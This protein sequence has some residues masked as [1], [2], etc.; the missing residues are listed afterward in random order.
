M[1]TATSA[2]YTEQR[3]AR[4]KL[5]VFAFDPGLG[6][7]LETLPISELTLA[8]GWE[9]KLGMGPV[10]EYVEVVDY[11][12][13]SAVFYAP[14][15]LN[16]SYLLA[17]EGLAP[18]EGIPQFHQQMVYAVAMNTI[19]HFERALGRV[20]LWAPR[21]I[22]DKQGRFLSAE[23][24]PRLRIY[25][26]ALREANAYYCPSKRAI[27]FGYCPTRGGGPGQLPGG[28][29]FTCLSYDIVAH[30]TTHALL[31]GLHPRFNEATNPDVYAL[32]EA[33]ADLVALLQRFAHPE[34]LEHQIAQTGG[35]LDRQNMLGQVAQQLG[36]ALGMRGALRSFLGTTERQT[37]AWTPLTPKPELLARTTE[38]HARGGILVAAV[39]SAFLAIYKARSA[40]LFRIASNGTGVMPEGNLHPDLVHR[41]AREAADAADDALTM[42]IRGLDYCPPVDV[43]FGV[44]LRAIITADAELYPEDRY[45]YRV[46]FI[47]AF[48][49]WGIYPEGIHSMSESVLR[50][51]RMAR[52]EVEGAPRREGKTEKEVRE[53]ARPLFAR[54]VVAKPGD[55]RATA[56]LRTATTQTAFETLSL[57]DVS[58]DWDLDASRAQVYASM[59]RNAVCVR[60]WLNTGTIRKHLSKLGLTLDENA[61]PTV[62]RDRDRLPAIEVHSVRVARRRGPRD[63]MLTDLVVEL[64]QRRRGYLDPKVQ[65]EFDQGTRRLGK[66][67][68]DFRFRRGCTLIIDPIRGEVRYVIPTRG[69]IAD[70][71]E[72]ERVRQF[73]AGEA[74]R[75]DNA[76]YGRPVGVDPA[77]EVFAALHSRRKIAPEF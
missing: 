29:V 1:A 12:P 30:E 22:R 72:L 11:D 70:D 3:P 71:R 50:F 44:Y 19:D 63:T 47:E 66:S 77:Q 67:D 60:A 21:L 58:L 32:H 54:M 7:Q 46:A 9:D 36:L 49:Q 52:L 25:P 38:P 45:S 76:F 15:D 6:A 64:C 17:Q 43:D 57:D 28:T 34:I 56:S 41:L 53:S 55:G 40:D 74:G 31:H 75:P 68:G 2:G 48:R 14:V 27:L 23:Y 37:R 65:K 35:H 5:R 59:Q 18:A 62:F 24:V 33:F 13:A 20:A 69:N 4:R 73:L 8:L 42:C 10:G 51:P 61:P 26:H 39:F 16:H